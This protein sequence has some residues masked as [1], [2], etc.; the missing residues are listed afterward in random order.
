MREHGDRQGWAGALDLA[1]NVK[2]GGMPRHVAAALAGVD[3]TRYPDDGE[4]REAVARRWGRRVEEAGVTAGASEA[5]WL[6]P[7][8]L[9]ARLAAVVHPAFTEPEAA[10]RA[11]GVPVLRVLRREADG[12]RLDPSAVPDEADLVVVGNPNN[13][14]GTLDEPATIAS[15]AR[16]GRTLVVDEAF[17]DYVADDGCSLAGRDD[18]PGLVVVR[19][20]TKLWGIPGV[21]AGYV[22]ADAATIAGLAACRQP[23]SVGAHAIA[24]IVACLADPDW[25]RAEAARAGL[26]REDAAARLASLPTVTVVPSAGPFLLLRVPD[27]PAV[28]A[29]LADRGIAVRAPTFPGLTPDHLRVAVRDH[30]A[31]DRLVAA[32]RAALHG[33]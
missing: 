20:V 4:A 28:R 1:V 33:P 7:R 26:D 24:A 5:F 2:A 31:T 29:A 23:W 16:P 9:P 12:W 15:L 27:G 21:R 10:L 8:V 6:L 22:L 18:V 30:D 11:A 13:P 14:T 25:A 32:L 17:M 3:V 19:T